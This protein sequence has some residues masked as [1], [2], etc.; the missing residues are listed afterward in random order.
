[1]QCSLQLTQGFQ[2]GIM[3]TA[4]KIWLLIF[5][6]EI[7]LSVRM[8]HELQVSDDYPGALYYSLSKVVVIFMSICI[9]VC[10]S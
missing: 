5:S 6:S 8:A 1:M 3:T 4:F 9:A 10:H 2:K 7:Q